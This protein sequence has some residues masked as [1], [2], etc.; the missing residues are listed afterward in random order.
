MQDYGPKRRK[1]KEHVQC[2]DIRCALGACR[3]SGGPSSRSRRTSPPGRGGTRNDSFYMI[4]GSFKRE[5]YGSFKWGF[6]VDIRQV[7]SKEVY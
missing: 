3:R 1:K 6:G 5:P 7:Y 2:V 4:R